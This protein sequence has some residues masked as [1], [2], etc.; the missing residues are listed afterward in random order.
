MRQEKEAFVLVLLLKMLFQKAAEKLVI[1][2][3]SAYHAAFKQA[4]AKATLTKTLQWKFSLSDDKA[5]L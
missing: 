1:D 2:G 5:N 4:I 3:K